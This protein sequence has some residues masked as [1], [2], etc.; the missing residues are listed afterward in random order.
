MISDTGYCFI[1][2]LF[3]IVIFLYRFFFEHSRGGG[4]G[5]FRHGFCISIPYCFIL[6]L[7]YIGSSSSI[8]GVEGV[9]IS[10]TGSVFRRCVMARLAEMTPGVYRQL[11]DK[12]TSYYLVIY[13]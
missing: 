3:Y 9:G 2:F 11:G 1:F 13:Y 10:D 8:V 7:F 12:V 4:S 6:L 5:D